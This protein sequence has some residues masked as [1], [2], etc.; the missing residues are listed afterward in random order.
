MD[1]RHSSPSPSAPSPRPRAFRNRSNS[2]PIVEALGCSTPEAELI[3]AEGRAAVRSRYATHRPRDR[4]ALPNAESVTAFRPQDHLQHLNETQPVMEVMESSRTDDDYTS[5]HT[6]S[7]SQGTDRTSSTITPTATAFAESAKSPISPLWNYSANLAR[8]VQ[9]QLDAITSYDP[10]STCHSVSEHSA[11]AERSQTR[12]S[13]DRRSLEGPGVLEIP[14]VRP[15]LRSAFSAWSSSDDDTED[16]AQEESELQLSKSFSKD[17]NTPYS[18]LRYYEHG[19]GSSFLLTPTP[20]EEEEQQAQ[21]EPNVQSSS[22][23]EG[24]APTTAINSEPD[25]DS[26]VSSH[27]PILTTSSTAPSV[28]S[29]STPSYFDGKCS[30][31]LPVPRRIKDRLL[32]SVSPYRAGGKIKVLAAASSFEGGAL[33]NVHDGSI[34]PRTKVLVDG[35]SFDLMRNSAARN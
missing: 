18:I 22:S 23:I 6:R 4:R 14:P 27:H 17:S 13:T 26:T 28:S 19:S 21:Q 31:A 7:P 1:K 24:K 11:K 12:I 15:P 2:L 32:A 29:I 10:I 16:E 5:H 9:A 8:F 3:L 33:A 34:E 25:C 35:L 30:R 20:L